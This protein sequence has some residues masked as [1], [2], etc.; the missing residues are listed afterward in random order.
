[1]D[2]CEIVTIDASVFRSASHMARWGF[3]PMV[4]YAVIHAVDG[5]PSF[6]CVVI[7]RDAETGREVTVDARPCE[8]ATQGFLPVAML[9]EALLRA[10]KHDA[11]AGFIDMGRTWKA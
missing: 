11:P 9:R 6:V 7:G 5:E 10:E 3:S 4:E 8:I 2:A 1:M